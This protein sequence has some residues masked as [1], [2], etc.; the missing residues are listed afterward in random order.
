MKLLIDHENVNYAGKE[1]ENVLKKDVIPTR[2]IGQ[3]S[4]NMIHDSLC[5]SVNRIP[6]DDIVTLKKLDK[7]M[8]ICK[9]CQRKIYIRNAIKDD[10]NFSW[11]LNFFDTANYGTNQLKGFIYSFGVEMLKLSDTELLLKCKDDTWIVAYVKYNRYKLFHNNYIATSVKDRCI[12]H[13]EFHSQ[14]EVPLR[15]KDLFK[16]I[17]MYDWKA[18]FR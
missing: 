15:L 1:R 6:E 7:S 3:K 14:K 4:T 16:Y 8:T 11:Y 13:G 10:E 5:T 2:F 17:A 18:H 9:K 12:L